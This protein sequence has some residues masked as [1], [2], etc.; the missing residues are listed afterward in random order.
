MICGRCGRKLKDPVSI[1]MGY[2][3]VCRAEMGIEEEGKRSVKSKAGASGSPDN[4]R[5]LEI[6]GQMS[7]FDIPEWLPEDMKGEEHE[8]G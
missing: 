7:V 5:E 1:R 6:P 2:G 8:R 3:P 4:E